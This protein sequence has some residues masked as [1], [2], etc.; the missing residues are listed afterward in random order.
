MEV[1]TMVRVNGNGRI[2]KVVGERAGY[3]LVEV[4]RR[5]SWELDKTFGYHPDEISAV[6]PPAPAAEPLDYDRGPR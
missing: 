2:G 5:N 6:A 1:G 4:Q 3:V